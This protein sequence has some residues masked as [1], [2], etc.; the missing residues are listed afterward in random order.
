[1]KSQ[2]WWGSLGSQVAMTGFLSLDVRQ[3]PDPEFLMS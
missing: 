3:V 2:R 1:M